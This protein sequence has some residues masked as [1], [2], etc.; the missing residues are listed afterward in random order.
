[1]SRFKF[2]TYTQKLDKLKKV[3]AQ[4]LYNTLLELQYSPGIFMDGSKGSNP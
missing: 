3:E 2:D 4:I 1:M